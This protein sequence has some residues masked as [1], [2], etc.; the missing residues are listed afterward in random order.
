MIYFTI[1]GQIIHI[2]DIV[3]RYSTINEFQYFQKRNIIVQCET[4]LY[5]ICFVDKKME[6][7][8]DCVVGSEVELDIK[9]KGRM[10]KY[11]GEINSVNELT[12]LKLKHRIVEKKVSE[13]FYK[14][15]NYDL[16]EYFYKETIMLKLIGKENKEEIH[17]TAVCDFMHNSEN[18]NH[19][20]FHNHS[21]EDIFK[22]LQEQKIIEHVYDIH[23]SGAAS[24]YVCKLL[25]K[26]E[27]KPKENQNIFEQ[28][29]QHNERYVDNDEYD[30]GI[31]YTHWND[32]LDNDE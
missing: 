11:K 26:P 15:S 14:N 3:T 19:I 17:I 30:H 24:G 29:N 28:G 10:W 5:T 9:V 1:K 21:N 16:I 8:Q 13:I 18:L 7:L 6:L 22:L 4:E 31:D 20:L 23:Q 25:Y 12:C 32:D 27:S 2:Y